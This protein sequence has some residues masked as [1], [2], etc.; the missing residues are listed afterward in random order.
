MSVSEKA[1]EGYLVKCG[2][3][4]RL[5]S[6]LAARVGSKYIE[7]QAQWRQI[8]ESRQAKTLAALALL[9]GAHAFVEPGNKDSLLFAYHSI[10]ARKLVKAYGDIYDGDD[11]SYITDWE[12]C[13]QIFANKE[14][15]NSPDSQDHNAS[16]IRLRNDL[17]DAEI[18]AKA[19]S[20]SK[21]FFSKIFG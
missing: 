8:G 18:R 9:D 20:E 14:K 3:D 10:I 13:C 15:T 2:V 19:L 21:G 12:S 7:F 4:L 16:I 5:A 17:R 6:Q 11:D 1:F